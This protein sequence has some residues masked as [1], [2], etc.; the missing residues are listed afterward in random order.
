MRDMMNCSARNIQ[1]IMIVQDHQKVEKACVESFLLP[2]MPFSL[3]E[4]HWWDVNGMGAS[5]RRG[6]AAMLRLYCEQLIY[7]TTTNSF[8]QNHKCVDETLI[9]MEVSHR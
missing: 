5:L 9:V 6:V 8:E 1:R 3:I 4:S 2:R 7:D